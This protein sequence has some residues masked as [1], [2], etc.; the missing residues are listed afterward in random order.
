MA[1]IGVIDENG[2]EQEQS[3]ISREATV[4]SDNVGEIDPSV[5]QR[6]KYDNKGQMSSLT[7]EC[8]ET[9]N[10]RQGD[11]KPK[12]TVEGIIVEGE[13]GDLRSLKNQ[14]EITFI[15]DIYEGSVIVERLSIVQSQDLLYYRP[16]GGDKQLAFEFQMQLKQPE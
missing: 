8:G 2:V 1:S 16:N 9:E 4:Q 15:S 3:I 12:L 5:T 6:I 10:R 13:I 11:N 14:E 7:S